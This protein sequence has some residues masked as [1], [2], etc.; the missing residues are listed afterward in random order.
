MP[1]IVSKVGLLFCSLVSPVVAALVVH[2]LLRSLFA[3]TMV[4][5]AI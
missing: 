5:N 3:V 4:V 2:L 1:T